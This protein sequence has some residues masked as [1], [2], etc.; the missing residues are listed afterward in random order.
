MITVNL[1]GGRGGASAAQAA[2]TTAIT[3]A[4]AEYWARYIDFSRAN[5]EIELTLEPDDLDTLA[6]ASPGSFVDTGRRQN[7]VAVQESQVARE[8]AG[9]ADANGNAADIEIFVNSELLIDDTFFLVDFNTVTVDTLPDVPDG[10]VDLFGTLVHE[11]AHGLGLFS[12]VEDGNG[13]I[14]TMDTLITTQGG[15]LVFT[16]AASQAVFGGVVPLAGEGDRSHFSDSLDDLLDAFAPE[17]GR[18]F[19]SALDVALFDD[20]GLPVFRPTSGADTLFGFM[21]DDQIHLSGG[22]DTYNALD[23]NDSVIGGSGVDSIFGGNGNDRIAGG[24]TGDRLFGENGNDVIAGNEGNDI[25]FGGLGQ[26][27]LNGNGGFDSIFGGAEADRLSGAGGRDRLEGGSGNDLV[28]GGSADDLLRGDNGNDQLRGNAGNDVLEG[29]IGNDTLFGGFGDDSLDGGSGDDTLAGNQGIDTL[30][31][32]VGNDTLIGG[33]GAD[34]L[35]FG[36]GGDQDSIILFEND[37]DT[38]ALDSALWGGGLTVSQVLDMFASNSNGAVVFNF[39][40]GNTLSVSG[41]GVNVA[42]I[43]DDITLF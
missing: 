6:S 15:N 12:L 38:I 41:P 23:G 33:T 39:G 26:D 14:S 42:S 34:T 16:G 30:D 31:G 35:I 2:A 4:A 1:V 7:G 19:I 29:G 13:E 24:A 11:V 22:N 27:T 28:F 25:I 8:L 17:N 43:E 21:T 36:D 10:Q 5:I 18:S 37:V 3:Q 9:G 40:G 32:G 20:L